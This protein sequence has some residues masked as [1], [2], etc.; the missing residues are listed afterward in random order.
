[1]NFNANFKIVFVLILVLLNCFKTF[2]QNEAYKFSSP[3][4]S[5]QGNNVSGVD[6]FRG[7][8]NSTI[9][10]HNFNGRELNFPLSISYTA[11]GIKVDQLASNIGLGWNLNAGGRIT[12]KVVRVPDDTPSATTDSPNDCLPMGY[13]EG[14]WSSLAEDRDYYTLNVFGL[15]EVLRI[16]YSGNATC[17]SNPKIRVEITPGIAAAEW[18]VTA[19]DGT[20]FYFGQGNAKETVTSTR[21]SCPSITGVNDFLLTK[22]VSRNKL[23][24]YELTYI[25]F[26]WL[27][28]IPSN[29]EKT[30]LFPNI[31]SQPYSTN[32]TYSS[33]QL[34]LSRIEHNGKPITSFKYE[35]RKDLKFVGGDEVGNALKEIVFY[36]FNA[37]NIEDGEEKTYKKVVFSYDYFGNA[38][39]DAYYLDKRLKL[40]ALTTYGYDN[41][42][43]NWMKGDEYRFEYEYPENLPPLNSMAQ[44]FLGLF[45]AKIQNIN[46]FNHAN[47]RA[48]DLSAAKTGTL[49]RITYPNKGYS[50]FEYEQNA[51]S[52]RY[53]LVNVPE[54]TQ[55]T[56]IGTETLVDYEAPIGCFG[57]DTPNDFGVSGVP[58]QFTGVNQNM[59][60]LVFNNNP[61]Q[62]T[63]PTK[64]VKT[65]EIDLS[66]MTNSS[67]CEITETAGIGVYA[68]HK[69]LPCTASAPI[70]FYDCD[71]SN[72][73]TVDG[74][75]TPTD[76]IY[77]TGTS[78]SNNFVKTGVLGQY[79]PNLVLSLEPGKYQLTIWAARIEGESNWV[80]VQIIRNITQTT[81]VSLAHVDQVD[82][83]SLL[84]DGFRIKNIT[85]F[86]ESNHFVSKKGYKYIKGMMADV[87]Y[88]QFERYI[89]SGNYE[90]V[91]SSRGYLNAP[92]IIH[93]TTVCETILNENDKNNGYTK[94][95]FST[96][97]SQ[98]LDDAPPDTLAIDFDLPFCYKS[99]TLLDAAS[100]NYN[101]PEDGNPRVKPGLLTIKGVY[102]NIGQIIHEEVFSNQ[103]MPF[104]R[105]S[106][107]EIAEPGYVQF[108][109]DFGYYNYT[110]KIEAKDYFRKGTDALPQIIRKDV[111]YEYDE[112]FHFPGGPEIGDYPYKMTTKRIES[113]F[114][115]AE[116]YRYGER[117]TI[118]ENTVTEINSPS[119]GI[120]E[121][122]Y[123]AFPVTSTPDYNRYFLTEIKHA[124]HGEQPEPITQFEYDTHGNKVQ[125][126]QFT[127]PD[128]VSPAGVE[129][130][131]YG[132]DNRFVIAKLTGVQ[133]SDI[134]QSRLESIREYA[135]N[136]V[137]DDNDEALRYKLN[138]LRIDF[139]DALITT[140]TYN[141]VYGV[142][143]VT[144]PKGYTIF[145]EYDAL[146][147]LKYTKERKPN[148]TDQ[149]N[150]LSENQYHTISNP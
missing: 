40:D 75:L 30:S 57:G 120:T 16:N 133:H 77:F 118:L 4:S 110:S 105:Y 47:G 129:S 102:N 141:P 8:M 88:D 94:Y 3:E 24:V 72:V 122:I 89:G 130:Y 59:N 143:S 44:D 36:K 125:T 74:C 93:Y 148:T 54:V 142:T 115:E 56:I 55:T 13:S 61:Q 108:L 34:M 149:F 49:T 51:L 145:S 26:N 116:T 84:R 146:G 80:R 78:S 6:M 76:Q 62:I 83:H 144:D 101:Y 45:N 71:L 14:D 73:V 87:L 107:P 90:T 5:A 64:F 50:V 96:V 82:S 58:I 68:I 103:I 65:I 95:H 124:K 32:S 126:M 31:I 92:S 17:Y 139:P 91:Y 98:S 20:K 48:F 123:T 2:A 100:L 21:G 66:Q 42:A 69:I 132:Y 33:N 11:N 41:G 7:T 27:T 114:T 63:M 111:Y 53:E 39:P 46:L 35:P 29:S 22:V 113:D 136:V 127:A 150:I 97:A 15:N 1:M 43:S 106:H 109:F 67:N 138:G 117:Y 99:N 134:S 38:A 25:N 28:A 70:T 104:I 19:E 86:D 137:S 128:V 121:F 140:Y 135:N 60:P 52:G 81:V 79:D 10:I 147:W 85:N 23:D 112:G 12:R 9:P 119:K 37:S 131:I 18:I